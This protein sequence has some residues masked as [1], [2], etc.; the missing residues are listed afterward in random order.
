MKNILDGAME[1]RID[2]GITTGGSICFHVLILAIGVCSL[3]CLAGAADVPQDTQ[4]IRSPGETL[5]HE[6]IEEGFKNPPDSAKPWVYWV[7]FAGGGRWSKEG[8]PTATRS[9]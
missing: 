2:T 1:R 4:A 6:N 9:Q 8:A 3:P 5:N 7:W